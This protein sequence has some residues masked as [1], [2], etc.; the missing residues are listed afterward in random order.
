MGRGNRCDR[1]EVGSM[2]VDHWL[3]IRI[4]ELTPQ[5]WRKLEADLTYMNDRGDVV[6]SYRRLIRKGIYEIPRGAWFLLPDSITYQ[7]Q[8][9]LPKLPTLEFH[10]NLDNTDRD[11]RFAEQKKAVKQMFEQEQGLIIRPPGTG[12]T[13]I[14]C[15]FAAAAGTRT[16]V[17]VHTEDILQQWVSR[18]ETLIP[19]LAGK[20]GVIRGKECRIGQITVATVQTLNRSYQD[21]PDE[22][23]A[24]W[25]CLIADEGHHVAAP[26]W[27]AIINSCPAFYRFGFTASDKRADGMSPSMRYI[28]GPV[29]HRQKFSSPVKL[30]VVKAKTDFRAAYRGPFDW[31]TLLDKLV[32]DT[33]RNALIAETVDREIQEGNS[34][35]VLS[36][37]IEHLENIAAAMSEDCEI[38]TAKRG[39]AK[40][41]EILDKFRAGEITCVLATQLADEALDVQRLNRVCLVHPGKHE[42][43]II[44]QIGRALRTHESKQDAVIYDFVDSRVRILDRQWNQRKRTYKK[45]G[46]SIKSTGSLLWR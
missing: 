38:L 40:R 18:I 20:I 35:L 12:K 46:I 34:V 43:R 19:E 30:H 5:Q 2:R 31:S 39:K 25:G 1:L 10:G 22:W 3:T 23:W 32:A 29:I 6:I 17:L 26:T 15:A 27:E 13:E 11:P 33:E 8:R 44:Q 37:R 16:L 28:I 7:D 14:A 45:N 24:Q 41:R 42:G 21:K 9:T 36:R 4:P